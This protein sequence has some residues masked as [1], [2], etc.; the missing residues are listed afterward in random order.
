MSME[1]KLT[2][3]DQF[4]FGTHFLSD[5]DTKYEPRCATKPVFRGLRK[6]PVQTRVCAHPRRLIS[7]CVIGLLESIIS[8]LASSEFSIFQLVSVAVK[9]GLSLTLPDTPKTGLSGC[10]SIIITCCGGLLERWPTGL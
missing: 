8:K 9:T 2:Y 6:T 5:D 4:I 10:G 3:F 1:K 7:A